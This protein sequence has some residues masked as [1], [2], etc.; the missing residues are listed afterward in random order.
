[1]AQLPP[2]KPE[3]KWVTDVTLPGY[4][5]SFMKGKTT[6]KVPLP[7]P[8]PGWFQRAELLLKE[9]SVDG[10]NL[11]TSQEKPD[12]YCYGAAPRANG[13]DTATLECPDQYDGVH[14]RQAKIDLAP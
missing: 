10:G 2:D 14:Y 11:L 12:A 5:D 4:R 8:V 9:V 6:N 7:V 3:W 1:M 13:S